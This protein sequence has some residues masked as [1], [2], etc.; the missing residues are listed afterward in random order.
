ML[1][2]GPIVRCLSWSGWNHFCLGR[3]LCKGFHFNDD[4]Y[5][6]FVLLFAALA[7]P[8]FDSGGGGC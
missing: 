7:R 3:C 2:L 5:V 1:L 4:H 8:F 6:S